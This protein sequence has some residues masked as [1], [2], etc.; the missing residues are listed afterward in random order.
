MG[1]QSA[2]YK[3]FFLERHGEAF[4]N[5]HHHKALES[6]MRDPQLALEGFLQA[7]HV[8][9]VWESEL[10]AGIGLPQLSYCSPFTRT[11]ATNTITF[12]NLLGASSLK[13]TI[14]ENCREQVI[15]DKIEHRRPAEYI[16]EILPSV[17]DK[18]MLPS[19]C[20][21]F[22]AN[23]AEYDPYWVHKPGS[24]DDSNDEPANTNPESDD[25]FRK[26]I[27]GVL[28]EIFEQHKDKIFIHITTHAGWI[29]MFCRILGR[30]PYGTING[31]MTL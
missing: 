4:S 22:E 21:V 24:D 1:D 13:T 23:F 29:K 15:P 14:V 7:Q 30:H 19:P 6:E 31:G 18:K 26:R 12:G 10:V 9:S 3:V 16:K 17:K 11:L 27:Q 28:G 2:D 25:S 5:V 8:Q 20:I